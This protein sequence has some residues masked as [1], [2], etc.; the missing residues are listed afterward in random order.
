MG[1]NLMKKTNLD[2]FTLILIIIGALNWGL[3]GLFNFNLVSWIFGGM[4]LVSRLIY[5]LVGLSGIYAIYYL[6]KK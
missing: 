2:I 3:I 6:T 4:S 1:E 5:I